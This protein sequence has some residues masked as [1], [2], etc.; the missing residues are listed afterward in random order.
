[1]LE[2]LVNPGAFFEKKSKEEINLKTSYAIIITASVLTL[3]NVVILTR[4]LMENLLNFTPIVAQRSLIAMGLIVVMLSVTFGWI[5]ISGIFYSFSSLLDGK[6]NFTR[7]LEFVAYGFLPFILSSAISLVLITSMCL[8]TDFS[9]ND[10]YYL[11]K[12]IMKSP[13]MIASNVI[14][15]ILAL[16]SANIWVFALVYSRNLTVKNAMIIVGIPLVMYVIYM[17]YLLY[18]SLI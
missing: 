9:I 5:V 8:F 14:S 18:K 16:W 11:E 4:E 13:Y 6:G 10:P 15:I 2:A 7:M 17:V 12:A 1:M 3:L